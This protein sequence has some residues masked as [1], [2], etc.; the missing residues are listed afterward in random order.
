MET[1]SKL[2]LSRK[3]GDKLLLLQKESRQMF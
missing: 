3:R 2:N 1:L